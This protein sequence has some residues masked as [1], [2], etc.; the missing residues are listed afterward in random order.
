MQELLVRL[1]TLLLSV[2]ILP[3]KLK[4]KHLDLKA[5]RYNIIKWNVNK[6]SKFLL[7]FEIT[8]EL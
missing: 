2:V 5:I 6:V 3:I 4:D 8:F 1:T 7:I